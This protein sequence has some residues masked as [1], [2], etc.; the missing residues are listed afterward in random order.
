MDADIKQRWVD[1]L[2]SGDY[3]QASGALRRPYPDGET[4]YCCLGVLCAIQPDRYEVP[5]PSGRYPNFA[6]KSD[7]T[8]LD[9]HALL[10]RDGSWTGSRIRMPYKDEPTAHERMKLAGMNDKG[11]SFDTIADYIEENL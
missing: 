2:R 1:A 3:T 9:S 11:E 8:P 7:H 6:R 4:A 5:V 10:A